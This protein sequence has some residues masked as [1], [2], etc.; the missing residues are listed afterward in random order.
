MD[1]AR[2]YGV[3]DMRVGPEPDPS[4]GSGSE[5]GPSD[6]GRSV[7]VGPA[8]V[9][10]RWD[11]RRRPEPSIGAGSRVRRR[12]RGRSVAWPSGRGRPSDRLS[13][14]RMVP[15]GQSQP[16]RG[17]S[18]RRSRRHGR[19]PTRAGGV[20]G[21]PAA[22]VAG[23]HQ[24]R[25]RSHPGAARR[26]P[27]TRSIWATP[28]SVT[29]WPSSAAGR[30]DC[31]RSAWPVRPAPASSSRSSRWPIGGP[32]PWR[33]GPTSRWSPDEAAGGYSRRDRRAWRGRRVRRGRVRTQ[34]STW[35][36]SRLGPGPGSCWPASPT[37]T[38]PRSP[39]RWPGERGS[40]LSS[41][42]E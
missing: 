1:V 37:T 26:G 38:G 3:G 15:A 27:C 5:P 24:R 40:R 7:R 30:S 18:L 29:P 31:S 17:R 33:W 14:V 13:T 21:P 11:R 12:G 25:R 6:H 8:L 19:R 9:R 2:L 16:V 20:A 22:P 36:C 28:G 34:L 10:R 32:P 4:V 39:P 23:E 41:Y 35:P 42:G